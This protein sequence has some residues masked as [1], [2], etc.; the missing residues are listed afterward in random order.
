M[1]GDIQHGEE[2]PAPD[3]LTGFSV[4]WGIF[5][6]VVLLGSGKGWKTALRNNQGGCTNGVCDHQWI[7]SMKFRG[8]KSGRQINSPMKITIH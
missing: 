2:K 8:L 1:A 5:M 6:L 3:F 4:A 7:T